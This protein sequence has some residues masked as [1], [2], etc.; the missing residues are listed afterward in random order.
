MCRT[1]LARKMRGEIA[2]LWLF[3]IRI[4]SSGGVL[5]SVLRGRARFASEGWSCVAAPRVARKG[6]ACLVGIELRG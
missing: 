5:W 3:E 6:E 2:K 4:R 1:R